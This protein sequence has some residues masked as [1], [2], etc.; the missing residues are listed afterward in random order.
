MKSLPVESNVHWFIAFDELKYGVYAIREQ[1]Y[2]PEQSNEW[3]L[4]SGSLN[5]ADLHEL[6]PLQWIW[7]G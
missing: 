2:L 4:F 3:I 7:H 6:I 5:I 1:A